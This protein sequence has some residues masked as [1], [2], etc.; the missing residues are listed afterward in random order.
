MQHFWDLENSNAMG[1]L[2][3]ISSPLG[4]SSFPG[5]KHPNPLWLQTA[6]LYH[7]Q[8]GKGG[9]ELGLR[10]VEKE[11]ICGEEHRI[12]DIRTIPDSL[13]RSIKNPPPSWERPKHPP[14]TAAETLYVALFLDPTTRFPNKLFAIF[15][16][17][18]PVSHQAL[19]LI[20]WPHCPINKF[21]LHFNLPIIVSI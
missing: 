7:R 20:L 17:P 19:T 12:A 5:I 16:S 1:D 14:H 6:S 13:H 21:I 4:K 15:P 8:H 11:A 10:R 18:F 2:G 3:F 9:K